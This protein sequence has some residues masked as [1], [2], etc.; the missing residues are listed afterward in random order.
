MGPLG[1]WRAMADRK[2]LRSDGGGAFAERCSGL[3]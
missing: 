3:S 2:L 1:V